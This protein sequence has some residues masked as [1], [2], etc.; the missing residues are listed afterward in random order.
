MKIINSEK[1]KM[2]LLANEQQESYKKTKICYIC[3]EKFEHRY[4]DDKNY[5]NFKG[6]CHC[7]GKYRSAAHSISNL[8]QSK[9]EEI[10]VVFQN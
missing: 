4:A 1:K 10:S 7:T 6:H 2:T 5:R 3:K 8:K 9:P